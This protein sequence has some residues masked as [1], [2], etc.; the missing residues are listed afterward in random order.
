MD[1]VESQLRVTLCQWLLKRSLL[2][3]Q[4]ACSSDQWHP[5]PANN[6]KVA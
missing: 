5:V 4:P 6:E 1:F 3:Q 2:E